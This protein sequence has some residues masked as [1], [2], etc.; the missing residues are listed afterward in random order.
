MPHELAGI[1]ISKSGIKIARFDA[2]LRGMQLRTLHT[3]PWIEPPPPAATSEGEEDTKVDPVPAHEAPT[4]LQLTLRSAELSHVEAYVGF[5]AQLASARQLTFPI[6]DLKKIESMIGFELEDQLPRSLEETVFDSAVTRMSRTDTELLVASSDRKQVAA[7][8]ADFAGGAIQP[9]AVYYEPLV[10]LAL[11]AGVSDALIVDI[12]AERTIILHVSAGRVLQ[13]RALRF[14]GDRID[15]VLA[16]DL[17]IPLDEAKRGKEQVGN[18]MGS[19]SPS[20]A[21]A[22]KA[23][24]HAMEPLVVALKQMLHSRQEEVAPSVL[25]TGGQSLLGGLFAYLTESLSCECKA[26]PLPPTLASRPDAHR[27]A[28]AYALAATSAVPR[29]PKIDFRRGEF[30]FRSDMSQFRAQAQRYVWAAAAVVALAFLSGIVRYVTLRSDDAALDKTLKEVT[31]KI[32][33]RE[34]TDY[35]TALIAMRQSAGVEK[36]TIPNHTVMDLFAALSKRI[37]PE[38]DI[39]A[40]EIDIHGDKMS[41]KGE[42]ANFE[43]IDKIV[44]AIKVDDCFKQATLGKSHKTPDGSKVEFVI[45]IDVGCGT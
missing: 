3:V 30:S 39:K 44:D 9:R 10:Y 22:T 1:D 43:N 6:T 23:L 5:P 28:L 26:L 24:R 4:R 2:S 11:S 18:I 45:S 42:S 34:M 17:Q 14:G 41:L 12:G 15:A 37:G 19:E 27:Y 31:K 29:Q 33:G 7:L 20:A 32:T 8:I 13:A 16:A 35:K 40:T 36:T 25:L 21:R 38:L